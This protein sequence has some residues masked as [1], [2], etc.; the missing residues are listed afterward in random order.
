MIEISGLTKTFGPVRAVDDLTLNVAPGEIFG[1]LGPNGAGKTTTVKIMTGLLRPNLGRVAICGHDVGKE[2]LAAKRSAALVPDEPYV[3][4]KLTGVEYLRFAAE[5]HG[6][7]LEEQRRRIPELLEM[8]ELSSRG[9]EL[10]ESYSHG[11]R[12]KL[13]LAG[14]IL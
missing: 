8:F 11:M 5:I 13:V 12:Q 3:Y 7:S 1:F 14:A 9:G 6:V 4:P 2:P 10:C